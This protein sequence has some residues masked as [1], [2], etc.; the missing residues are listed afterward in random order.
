MTNVY[1]RNYGFIAYSPKHKVDW[2]GIGIRVTVFG[3]I[4]K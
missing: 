4:D 3:C 2:V 1:Y